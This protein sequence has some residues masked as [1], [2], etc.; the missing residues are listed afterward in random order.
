MIET[1]AKK[2]L[3]LEAIEGAEASYRVIELYE[4]VA[5]AAG[6]ADPKGIVRFRRS[7]GIG[8][9]C[10]FL[11]GR[12]SD[13]IY[14]QDDS[15]KGRITEYHAGK[16]GYVQL[17]RKPQPPV[18]PSSFRIR[19]NGR[20]VAIHYG[21][22]G[23]SFYNNNTGK[24]E[25]QFTPQPILPNKRGSRM[26]QHD[27]C[28]EVNPSV[29]F[30]KYAYLMLCPWCAFS[31]LH[32]PQEKKRKLAIDISPADTSMRVA[33]SIAPDIED[34]RSDRMDKEELADMDL[35]AKVSALGVVELEKIMLQASLS[36][37]ANADDPAADMKAR[38]FNVIKGKSQRGYDRKYE[39]IKLCVIGKS[40]LND[41][42][43]TIKKAMKEGLLEH[44]GSVWKTSFDGKQHPWTIMD[45]ETSGDMA[46][47]GSEPEW[48]ARKI[49]T[50]GM[51]AWF[52]NI[53]RLVMGIEE[54]RRAEL[55]ESDD[56]T[57]H[58]IL[59]KAIARGLVTRYNAATKDK[60]HRW[61]D[62]GEVICDL[63]GWGDTNML[64]TL[65]AHFMAYS[66][67]E[68][69]ELV[70]LHSAVPKD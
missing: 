66:P 63:N 46:Q 6:W 13:S 61:A 55:L 31:P 5:K 24:V 47:P 45:D 29:D 14:M 19:V 8:E 10:T 49:V 27:A 2:G 9:G 44:N 39:I 57:I 69:A 60:T 23:E 22:P 40:S 28:I 32:F 25:T 11:N 38:I 3:D 42:A 64:K 4:Q 36:C 67:E 16:K 53:E 52:G 26:D 1:K 50:D 18:I 62:T 35:T 68:L 56:S 34:F 70:A 65:K 59:E 51:E 37:R 17:E 41:Y 48:L 21:S 43:S 12:R 54:A 58:K 7:T 33:P 15:G 20:V 30:P